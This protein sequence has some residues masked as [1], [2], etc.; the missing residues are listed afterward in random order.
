[1]ANVLSLK[2]RKI[3]F[4]EILL[5]IGYHFLFVN[6]VSS[7]SHLLSTCASHWLF[8]CFNSSSSLR[9][10][11]RLR[12]YQSH[13]QNGSF[14]EDWNRNMHVVKYVIIGLRVILCGKHGWHMLNIIGLNYYK[15]CKVLLS[16]KGTFYFDIVNYWLMH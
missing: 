3:C 1:M 14:E 12:L 10:Q 6:K 2:S 16:Y 4:V 13:V 8:S 7:Y 15:M 5:M 11:R 9:K